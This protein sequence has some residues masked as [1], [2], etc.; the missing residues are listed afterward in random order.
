M[1]YTLEW[2]DDDHIVVLGFGAD[3]RAG[4]EMML[5]V[6]EIIAR[7]DDLPGPVSVIND[8][9]Y[10]T[11]TLEDVISAANLARRDEVSLFHHPKVKIIIAVS[12]NQ[13][14]QASARGLNSASFGN[15]NLPVFATIDEALAYARQG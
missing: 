14:I 6:G 4:N 12:T 7:L 8:L 9:R 10:A 11:F 3:F 2:L 5:M 1:S 15:L 13:L